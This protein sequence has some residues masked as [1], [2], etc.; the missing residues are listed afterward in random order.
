MAPLPTE[1]DLAQPKTFHWS[2]NIYHIS[3]YLPNKSGFIFPTFLSPLQMPAA[4]LSCWVNAESPLQEGFKLKE[5]VFLET[6][7]HHQPSFGHSLSAPEFKNEFKKPDV[8]PTLWNTEGGIRELHHHRH[9]HCPG[10]PTQPNH[11][12]A[13]SKKIKTS[14]PQ[15]S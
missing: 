1:Q 2:N 14:I 12:K 6:Q 4:Y 7:I 15:N 11:H 8:E 3:W 10:L 5:E 13:L 9:Q